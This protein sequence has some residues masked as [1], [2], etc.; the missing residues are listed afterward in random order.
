MSRQ[1]RGAA[2][3]NRSWLRAQLAQKPLPA[4]IVIAADL[5]L[6]VLAM[7]VFALFHHVL[8]HH[9]DAVGIAS[10]RGAQAQPAAVETEAPDGESELPQAGE[11]M[12]DA[13]PPQE[14]AEGSFGVKFADKFTSGGVERTETGYRSANINLEITPYRHNDVDY[15]V[16]DFYLRDISSFQTGFAKDAFGRGKYESVPVTLARMN[17]IAGVN[18]DYYGGRRDGIVAHNGMLYR[19]DDNLKR[20]VCVLYWD[21][22]LETYSP[23]G[24]DAEAE[25]ARGAYQMWNFGPKL[26]DENGQAMEEFNSDVARRN[27]RTAIGYFEPGH[28]CFVVV[29]GRSE[30]SAGI[31]LKNL[32]RL[33]QGLGCVRAYNLD[34]GE[35]SKL[36]FGTETVNVPAG[37]GRMST[38]VIGIVEP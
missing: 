11:D 2:R 24:F 8:P 25:M 17:A 26:L 10:Q 4:W 16:A 18:G 13:Q 3:K 21:G 20:D 38:D 12:A 14:D 7:L 22:T 30:Q 37:D 33:M 29:D 32:S 34:G 28:Y 19:N 36:V 15:Y 23:Q 6:F 31:S 9:E 35:T 5:L 27:P 1:K